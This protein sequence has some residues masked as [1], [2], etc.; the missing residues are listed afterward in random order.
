LFQHINLASILVTYVAV[1]FALS[2]HE[3]AHATASYLLGDDTAARM[4]RMTLNPLAH[5]DPI[6]TF[7]LPLLGMISGIRVLGWAKPVPVDTSRLTR[8]YT[9]RVGYAMVAAAGP[10][11]NLVQSLVFLLMLCVVIRVA[12]P[13]D[14]QSRF[15][16]FQLAMEMPVDWF[17]GKG[18]GMGTALALSLLGKLVIINVGLAIFNLLPF[19]PLDGAG[20]LRGFL[21][22][23]SLATFDRIQPVITIVLLICFLAIPAVI[24]FILG[25][26]FFVAETLYLSPLARLLLGA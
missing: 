5:I 6:G 12:V 26:F 25:P 14:P 18:L 22:Y 8:K 2:V 9:A 23:Q 19:G 10:I 7:L 11:S 21:P 4:G 20:I 17:V 3:A 16:V 15:N 24:S 1:L 13:V